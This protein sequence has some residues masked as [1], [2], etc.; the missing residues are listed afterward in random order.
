MLGPVPGQYLWHGLTTA[1]TTGPA[2]AKGSPGRWALWNSRQ[3]RERPRWVHPPLAH[4]GAE[5]GRGVHPAPQGSTGTGIGDGSRSPCC[6]QRGAGG[7]GDGRDPPESHLLW[8]HPAPRWRRGAAAPGSAS[9][10]WLGS[11]PSCRAGAA[12]EPAP[13]NHLPRGTPI[14]TAPTQG[15]P[16]VLVA[17]RMGGP[18]C[19]P[20]PTHCRFSWASDFCSACWWARMLFR[21]L[22][23]NNATPLRGQQE[24]DGATPTPIPL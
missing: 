20:K 8:S 17:A 3:D 11:A 19:P 24:G 10:A 13:P 14:H 5:T 9:A 18:R 7:G 22:A 23:L 6:A 12:A 4:Q 15:C 1:A 21:T 16:K 2:A